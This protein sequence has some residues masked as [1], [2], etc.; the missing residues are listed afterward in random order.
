[1]ICRSLILS[2]FLLGNIF[3]VHAA[4]F[5]DITFSLHNKS[6]KPIK[7]FIKNR[8]I[9]GEF[10]GKPGG[11]YLVKSGEF[12]DKIP[13][14]KAETELT[15]TDTND[16]QLYHA[17]F[18]VGKTIY[19]NWDDK[20]KPALYPQRGPRKGKTKRTDKGYSLEDNVEQNDI[21]MVDFR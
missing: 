7:V 16:V 12:L 2:L 21:K 3:A 8:D 9:I 10:V 17:L 5:E 19:V 11:P 4:V 14:V 6:K 15:I 13:N 1:M 18:A 20:H